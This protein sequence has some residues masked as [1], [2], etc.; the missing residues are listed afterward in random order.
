[1]EKQVTH[2]KLPLHSSQ[3]DNDAEIEKKVDQ[4]LD[5]HT[6]V[7]GRKKQDNKPSETQSQPAQKEKSRLFYVGNKKKDDATKTAVKEK[8]SVSIKTK[9]HLGFKKKK[10][11]HYRKGT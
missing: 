8:K 3:S 4:I 2:K 6:E 10:K 7:F 9:K 11:E 1:M 5:A